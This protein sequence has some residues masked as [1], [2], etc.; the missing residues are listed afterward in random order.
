VLHG[1]AAVAQGLE[2][3]EACGTK[4]LGLRQLH[5]WQGAQMG[6][7]AKSRACEPSCAGPAS[8]EGGTQSLQQ[9]GSWLAWLSLALGAPPADCRALRCILAAFVDSPNTCYKLAR[10]PLLSSVLW[11]TVLATCLPLGEPASPLQKD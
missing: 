6:P 2:L 3:H 1:P 7:P 11:G 8:F 5:P 9:V 10:L 4:Q